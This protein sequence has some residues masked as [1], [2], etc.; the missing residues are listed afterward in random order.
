MLK[1]HCLKNANKKYIYI[2]AVQRAKKGQILALDKANFGPRWTASSAH[3]PTKNYYIFFKINILIFFYSNGFLW[4][5]VIDL[6]YPLEEKS[7]RILIFF[8]Q[9]LSAQNAP[10][11]IPYIKLLLL[12]LI[13]ILFSLVV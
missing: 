10:A 9:L 13:K 6:K 4:I 12:L 2:R 5:L 8:L 11:L 1:I 3:A 7:K